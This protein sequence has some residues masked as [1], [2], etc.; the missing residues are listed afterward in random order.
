[1]N[2]NLTT[3]TGKRVPRDVHNSKETTSMDGICHLCNG[4]CNVPGDVKQ[5]QANA[6]HTLGLMSQ[7][8]GTPQCPYAKKA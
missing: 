4:S 6:L 3:A 8:C 7:D 1:M 5:S 2:L